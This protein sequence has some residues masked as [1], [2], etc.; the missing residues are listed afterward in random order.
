MKPVIES[1]WTAQEKEIAKTALINAQTR[2]VEAII[3]VVQEQARAV[4][5]IEDLWRLNDFLSA[6]RFD[7]DGK[8]DDREE[9]ILFALAKL[10]KEGWLQPQDIEGLAS[11]KRSKISALTR[12]L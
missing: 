3:Q 10:T 2:E 4:E 6:R 1:Q 8:Y 9:E 5:S 12:V 11:A 7:I